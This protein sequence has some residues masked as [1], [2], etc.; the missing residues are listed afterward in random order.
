MIC[1]AVSIALISSFAL[2]ATTA[3]K[4]SERKIVCNTGRADTFIAAEAV[5]PGDKSVTLVNVVLMCLDAESQLFFPCVQHT[6]D[7]RV[8]L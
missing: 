8:V 4:L 1:I 3:E 2:H 7:G 6:S 5:V